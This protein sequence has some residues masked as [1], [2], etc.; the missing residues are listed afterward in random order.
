[1]LKV[2]ETKLVDVRLIKP[3]AFEDFRGE[4]IMTYNEEQYCK[5]AADIK[6]VESNICYVE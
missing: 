4:Y 2:E 5:E 6:F 1:M 3:S